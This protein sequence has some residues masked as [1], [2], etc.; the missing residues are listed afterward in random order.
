MT[1]TD[2]TYDNI[3]D[4]KNTE[5]GCSDI[6]VQ[7]I[8]EK[9]FDQLTNQ[10]T[11]LYTITAE[12]I[13]NTTF[14]N[15]DIHFYI[16][17]LC[18][19]P[20]NVVKQYL[21]NKIFLEKFLFIKTKKKIHVQI[22]LNNFKKFKQLLKNGYIIDYQCLILM[23][24]NGRTDML[25]YILDK[26]I[27]KKNTE[28]RHDLLMY[29]SEFGHE[30]MYFYL[31]SLNLIPNLSIYKK[32]VIGPG[33][34]MAIV[35]DIGEYI[36]ITHC[37]IEC[38]FQ[39]SNTDIVLYVCSEALHNDTKINQN[40]MVYPLLCANIKLAHILDSKNM[41]NWHDDLYYSCILS[42]SIQMVQFI[43]SKLPNIHTEL[44]LD[45]SHEKRG[46]MTILLDDMMYVKNKKIYFSH[47]INYAIQSKSIDMLKY[48][49]NLG[50]TITAS[51]F[52][53]CIK[54]GNI[55]MLEY[56]CKN[57]TDKLPFYF[58]HYFG[59]NSFINDKYNKAKILVQNNLLP[60]TPQITLKRIDYQ[61]ESVHLQLIS[62]NTEITSDEANDIDYLMSYQL[63][64][65]P[66]NGYKENWKLLT[67]LRLC[68][69]LSKDI[70]ISE[71]N[72]KTNEF[73]FVLNNIFTS[74]Y[75]VVDN[76]YI[77]DCLVL[78]GT[79]KQLSY[80][81]PIFGHN[82]CPSKSIVRQ[83]LFYRQINKLCYLL[84]HKII[85]DYLSDIYSLS[86]FLSDD[87]INLL[88]QKLKCDSNNSNQ[89]LY[90][91]PYL[92]QSENISVINEWINTNTTNEKI[93][94]DKNLW[95]NILEIDNIDLIQK[96]SQ[97]ICKSNNI[98]LELIDWAIESDLI[99]VSLYLKK[100]IN[101]SDT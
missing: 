80:Y 50:Y 88:R 77:I 53:T 30:Q 79:F 82:R 63:F 55:Q 41:I 93:I 4:N 85:I 29:C 35:K 7:W 17:K 83:I 76:Q 23:S 45:T 43:E 57:Y 69:E 5:N 84:Q 16:N 96:F 95:K 24:L 10:A 47:T 18:S 11:Q 6:I 42:G 21:E 71:T 25:K 70:V 62:N 78:F 65:K 100:F 38:A 15:N 92:L 97:W 26:N 90:Q 33:Y 87:V 67:R 36:G 68:L 91:L 46:N 98:L 48:I 72:V 81:Y 22:I 49:H 40:L 2:S 99:E 61:R 74:D 28:L 12:I 94:I 89:Q 3:T 14:G 19:R 59:M 31:R 44:I 66:V 73:L 54:Q 27:L 8:F 1:D 37:I 60:I 20:I 51:N 32:A 39:S 101:I 52:I 34:S 64:F 13:I 75:N 58:I 56:L 9:I 86:L